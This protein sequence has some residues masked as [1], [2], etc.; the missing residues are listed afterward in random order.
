LPKDDP[1]VLSGSKNSLNIGGKG[2]LS[3]TVIHVK[4]TELEF[5]EFLFIHFQS[6]ACRQQYSQRRRYADDIG[7]V[8][9]R[10]RDLNA[11]DSFS[12][13]TQNYVLK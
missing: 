2:K 12:T 5:Y 10:S 3:L 13:L 6:E 7:F 9:F 4:Q 11:Q 1:T 8:I